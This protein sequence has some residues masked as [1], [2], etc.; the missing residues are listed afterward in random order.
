MEQPNI[1]FNEHQVQYFGNFLRFGTIPQN[2]PI[3]I[4][5]VL[6]TDNQVRRRRVPPVS[7]RDLRNYRE[8]IFK[9]QKKLKKPL[10]ESI[11]DLENRH[12]CLKKEL[13][14]SIPE[15]LSEICESFSEYVE[16]CVCTEYYNDND[17]KKT[18]LSCGHVFCNDCL[19]KC[20]ERKQECPI[21][22][23][24]NPTFTHV[25]NF[26]E[27]FEGVNETFAE[28]NEKITGVK[29]RRKEEETPNKRRKIQIKKYWEDVKGKDNLFRCKMCR[30]TYQKKN[31][32]NHWL[33]CK[34][35]TEKPIIE[36]VE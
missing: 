6:R 1:V 17:R 30:R 3:G 23:R 7:R 12:E 11:K 5:G 8:R 18:I 22:K 16:C 9:L 2:I 26:I 24:T 31:R 34:N 10:S 28:I 25:E 36:Y 19:H 20:F 4:P 33:V 35:N 32:D 27:E 29:R 21:C 13:K 15:K 14:K